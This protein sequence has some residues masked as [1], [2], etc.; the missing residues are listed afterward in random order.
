MIADNLSGVK[1]KRVQEF[2]SDHPVWLHF[3]PTYSSWLNQVELWFAKIS[4]RWDR[5]RGVH[6]VADLKSK[7]T[8][9]IR[10]YNKHHRV[11]N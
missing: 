9:Y 11:V 7:L 1:T 5:P 6:S 10:E 3:T 4:S 8:R 2:L